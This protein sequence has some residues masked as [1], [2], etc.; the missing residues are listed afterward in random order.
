MMV[1]KNFTGDEMEPEFSSLTF[2]NVP[3]SVPGKRDMGIC[4]TQPQELRNPQTDT[5]EMNRYINIMKR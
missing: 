3:G 1:L 4:E 5:S 2:Y